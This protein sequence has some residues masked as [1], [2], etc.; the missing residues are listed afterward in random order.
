MTI[1][2]EERSKIINGLFNNKTSSYPT[3]IHD[4]VK[5]LRD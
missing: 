2:K 5:L 3:E 4:T 1:S